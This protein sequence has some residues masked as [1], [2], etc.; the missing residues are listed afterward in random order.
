M[1]YCPY[2]NMAEEAIEPAYRLLGDKA[3]FEP[4]Y[5]YYEGYGGGGPNYCMDDEDLY[6]SMHGVQEANQN[7]RENCVQDLY[8]TG[9][10]FDFALAMNDACTSQNAD[11]C[12]EAVAEKLGYD[13]AAIKSCQA[14]DYEKYASADLAMSK[15]WD[16][17]G[18][19]TVFVNGKLYSGSRTPEGY[20]QALCAEFEDT[21]AECATQ[22]SGDT[23]AVA[24]GQC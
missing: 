21:P 10:W 23:T 17:T 19:P 15:S 4:K 20:K 22:L 7:I 2:G 12:W 13:V 3:K 18:S 16:A 11:K 9:A 24:S 5:I 14:Q 8:G 1:S 6:C